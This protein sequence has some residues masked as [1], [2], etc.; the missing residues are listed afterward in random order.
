MNVNRTRA[1]TSVSR[2]KSFFLNSVPNPIQKIA[3][4][5]NHPKNLSIESTMWGLRTG[6]KFENFHHTNGTDVPT[7]SPMCEAGSV[8]S[9]VRT[10]SSET[11]PEKVWH[12]KDP[13]G[14]VQGPFTLLQLSKWT[15]YFPCDLRVWLTFESEE[16]SLLLTEVLSKQ[17]TVFNQTTS[18][19]T[20]TKATSAGM[21]GNK[22]SPSVDI[23]DLSPDYSMLN[24]S[25][26]TVQSNKYSV[27]E[28]QSVNSPEDC[29]SLSTKSVQP[30]DVHTLNSQVQCHTKHSVFVQSRGSPYGLTDLHHD[31]AHGGCS[32]EFNHHHSSAVLRSSITVQM[33]CNGKSNVGSHHHNQHASWSENQNDSKN[34]SQGV[35]MKDL[36]KNLPTRVGKDAPSAVFA[37]SPSESRTA[38]SQHDGS[39]SA[40]NPSFFDEHHSSIA[41]AKPKSCAPAT[42]VE[43]RGSSSPSGM[44][45]HSERV[46]IGIPRSAP[47]ASACDMCKIEENMSQQRTVDT[48]ISNASVTQSPES[49]IFSISSPDNQVI[50]RE[51]PSPTPRPE[52]KE[53]LPSPT[54][55]PEN[56][57]P[58]VDNSPTP[59]PEN[60][61]PLPSPT[62]RPEN[63]EPVV[64]N[65]PT[66]RPE[67]KEPVVDNSPTPRPENKEPVVDNSGLTPASPE[68]LGNNCSPVSDPCK[69]EEIVKQP[70]IHETDTSNSQSE[71]F[72][73]S[74]SN[75]KDVEREF[76]C[77]TR[78]DNK[79]PAA[80]NSLL[81]SAAT[82]SLK[83]A[84]ASDTDTCK[85]EATVNQQKPLEEDASDASLSRSP[86][87][88]VLPISSTD[89]QDVDRANLS[90]RSG[91]KELSMDNSGLKSATPEIL[92]TASASNAC[93]MEE[94]LDK[95]KTVE[96][97]ASDGPVTLP[98]KVLLVSSPISRFDNKEPPVD[99]SLLISAATE[100]LRTTSASDIDTCKMEAAVNQRKAPEENASDASLNQSPHSNAFPVSSTDN[101][102]IELANPSPTPWSGNKEPLVDNS[103]LKSG[104]PGN[105]STAT[106]SASNACN[107]VKILDKKI[108]AE[109]D[110]S[111]G[112]ITLPS[113]VSL[114]SS[115]DNLDTEHEFPCQSKS[116]SMNPLGDNSVLA[117]AAPENA[118]TSS[119]SASDRCK[120]EMLDKKAALETD[121]SNGSVTPS[122]GSKDFLVTSDNQDSQCE[123]PSSTPR[124]QNEEPVVDT[125]RL[126]LA[127]PENL[128][129]KVPDD[130]PD[131]FAL[132]KSG[133]L[134]GK[135]Y[136]MESDFKGVEEIIRNELYSESTVFTRENV[137]IDPSCGTE[138]IDV[139]DVLESLMEQTCETPYM[140]G[141]TTL[142]DFL[143]DSAEEEPQC[144]SPIALSAWGEPSYYQGHAVD[145][146]LWGVQDDPINDM[147]SLL[148]PTPVLQPSSG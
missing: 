40:T 18:V 86:H 113:K 2:R 73:V 23:N 55:R 90:P 88:N 58:V 75:N 127:E 60:K 94:I 148:S 81:T 132:P 69:M 108:T 48:D 134:T 126:Q 4:A 146:S 104:A 137:V 3:G 50:D 84:S 28:R 1:D 125:S 6:R 62:P 13:S 101:Q 39:C 37:W 32:G 136:D 106:A 97:D 9:S 93:K 49:K 76:W 140:H 53:P 41:S 20:G 61:E 139:S 36:P 91:N 27:L 143:A 105:L 67:N 82:E 68:K 64:D 74:F 110:V 42:P 31:G 131:A 33:N 11:E 17:Q 109:T 24:S 35:S 15:S 26:V 89:N 145:S 8:S 63:K 111:D 59:R 79:E 5:N 129:T 29:L 122:S 118:T 45:S 96:T 117:S 16:R 92:S 19:I 14:N 138:S 38:S 44:L 95:K 114:V 72:H 123:Y 124:T 21:E 121:A 77:T 7:P 51:F 107:M 52:N 128:T 87:S 54:P 98:S 147:W 34:S 22:N 71:V 78:P 12:Y 120:M 56:K 119:A 112:S 10:M 100:S 43:D 66:P 141:T 25:L 102:D 99:S 135:L 130:S 65:S 85:M 142:E 46:P 116:K 70:K 133:P 80:D 103:G 57:E 144:A 83:I 30:N 47:S 115:P